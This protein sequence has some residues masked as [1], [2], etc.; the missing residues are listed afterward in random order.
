MNIFGKLIPSWVPLAVIAFLCV[1]ILGQRVQVSNAKANVARSQKDLSDYKLG[2]SE[3]RILA[4]RAQRTE[5][6]RKQSVVTKE[7]T[8][9]TTESNALAPDVRRATGAA[10]GLRSAATATA[11]RACP[12]PVPATAGPSEPDTGALDLFTELLS[13]HSRE[14][15]EVG[16]SADR[17]RIA[18]SACE[19]AFDGLSAR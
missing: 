6:Q 13:R 18:G 9:A 17:L 8:N 12:N 15:V 3:Q 2:Q 7:A 4:D 5:E 16:E 1:L 14:L 19:R 11:R 10:D